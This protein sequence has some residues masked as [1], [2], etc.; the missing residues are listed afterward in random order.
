MPP[1]G[2]CTQTFVAGTHR[3]LVL[4]VLFPSF[5]IGAWFAKHGRVPLQGVHQQ[6]R[7][8]FASGISHRWIGMVTVCV[9]RTHNSISII[10]HP[11]IEKDQ[12]IWCR[13]NPES[14]AHLS[15]QLLLIVE[16]IWLYSSWFIGMNQHPFSSVI[17]ICILCVISCIFV[18]SIHSLLS[19]T[20]AFH[21]SQTFP[22]F[23]C[24]ITAVLQEK[25]MYHHLTD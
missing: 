18:F 7:S 8:D 17:H 2:Y 20:L 15:F 9:V 12:S 13:K 5:S 24:L 23:L 11:H 25:H 3:H 22:L 16:S 1:E 10:H 19:W 21:V 4:H 14:A 6:Y